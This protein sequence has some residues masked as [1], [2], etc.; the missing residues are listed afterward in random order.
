MVCFRLIKSYS[1]TNNIGLESKKEIFITMKKIRI[2]VVEDYSQLRKIYTCA[3]SQMKDFEVTGDFSNAEECI[4]SLEK[5]PCD[6]ILMDLGLPCMN[7]LEATQIIASKY[8]DKKVVILTS[9]EEEQEVLACMASGASGYLLKDVDL[10]VLEKVIKIVNFGALWFDPQ[11][12][13]VAKSA[14]P[15]PNSTNFENLYCKYNLKD[16]K[17]SLTKKEREVLK[18][19]SEG[20]SN[21]EIAEILMVSANTAKVHV[22]NILS[23]L[24]VTDR[25]QAAVLAV[26]ARLF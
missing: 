19:V 13:H 11:I 6:V 2:F 7:G 15:K 23:K 24:S 5:T 1:P 3:L 16:V 10:D 25:V 26:K 8:P 20:K 12:A 14:F 9:H 17:D 22:G 18:L 4:N 21:T